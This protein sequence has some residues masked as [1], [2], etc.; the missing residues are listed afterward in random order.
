MICLSLT[1][2]QPVSLKSRGSQDLWAQTLQGSLEGFEKVSGQIPATQ[3][4]PGHLGGLTCVQA[5]AMSPRIMHHQFSMSFLLVPNPCV[6]GRNQVAQEKSTALQRN[7][8]SPIPNLI[9]FP[10]ENLKF[11]IVSLSLQVGHH[12]L[13]KMINPL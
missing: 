1:S 2:Q 11:L 10:L 3:L 13:L 4:C 12:L 9:C 7:Q 6:L 5:Y 8:F